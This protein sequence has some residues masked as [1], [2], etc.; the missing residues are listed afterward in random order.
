MTDWCIS[1][2]IRPV[3]RNCFF[4]RVAAVSLLVLV[5]GGPARAQPSPQP[6]T[7]PSPAAVVSDSTTALITKTFEGRPWLMGTDATV[8]T[9]DGTPVI[10]VRGGQGGRPTSGAR[11][12]G[13]VAIAKGISLKEGAID[14]E[15]KSSQRNPVDHNYIGVIFRVQDQLHYEL[16]YLRFCPGRLAGIQYASVSNGTDPWQQFQQPQYTRYGV[17]ADKRWIKVHIELRGD[18]M[19]LYLDRETKPALDMLLTG[20]YSAGSVGFWAFPS[21]GEGLFR[22]LRVT[23]GPLPGPEP[24]K[25]QLSVLPTP[26]AMVTPPARWISGNQSAQTGNS[27]VQAESP[28]KPGNIDRT[29]WASRQMQGVKWET[30]D[31]DANA[32]TK[33]VLAVAGREDI[34]RWQVIYKQARLTGDFNLTAQYKGNCRIGLVCADGQRGFIGIQNNLQQRG[35]LRIRRTGKR[36]EFTL[37]GQ[38]ATYNKALVSEEIPFYFGIVLDNGMQCEL[39]SIQV[40]QPGQP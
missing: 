30:M 38:P 21:S 1:L 9:D 3:K 17:F 4:T 23:P 6:G 5:A 24:V 25:G 37:N 40:V 18:R 34:R 11:P 12:I 14:F 39:A 26:P 27:T 28:A 36:L 15:M 19:L 13:H 35:E 16:L 20:K 7:P 31:L 2:R 32:V 8:S 22:N 10:S 29:L 33:G